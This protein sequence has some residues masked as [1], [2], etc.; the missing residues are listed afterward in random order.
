MIETSS[1]VNEPASTT[2]G[3]GTWSRLVERVRN[4]DSTALEELYRVFSKG[5]RFYLWHHLGPQDLDDRVHDAFL[6]VTESI[7]NGE[8]REPDRLLGFVRT[9]VR[10]QVATQIDHAVHAR[11]SRFSQEMLEVLHDRRPG[12]EETAMNIE[13]QE[14]AMRILRSI[15]ARDREVLIRFYL[16]EQTAPEICRELKLTETQFR[17]IK[18]R[19]KARFGELGKARLS[20]RR[21]FQQKKGKEL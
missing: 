10:R 13:T 16:R 4:G 17:L 14:L 20:L 15:P 2:N 3:T 7:Q 12:P 11:R 18:S 19:A 6:T 21:G 9:V 1:T 8:L 5:I